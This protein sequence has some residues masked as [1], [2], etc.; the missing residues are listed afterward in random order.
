MRGFLTYQVYVTED[1]E[2][3]TTPGFTVHGIRI[4]EETQEA[5][6][7]ATN[8]KEEEYEG[9]TSVSVK[10]R[11]NDNLSHSTDTV[12]VYLTVKDPDGTVRRIREITLTEQIN[13]TY[14]WANLP[15]YYK[16]GTLIEYSV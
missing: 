6:I 1:T 13:W 4:D 7:V 12:T 3:N 5:Y 16:D 10:K 9:V 2:G 11:W 15:K 14:T 8:A